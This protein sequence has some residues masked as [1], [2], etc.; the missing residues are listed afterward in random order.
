MTQ[1][2]IMVGVDVAKRWLDVQ[3]LDGE[4]FRVGNDA[5]GRAELVAR[6]VA[7]G[8]AAV[9]L[10]A[11]GGYERDA[12]ADFA[13]AGIAVRRLDPKRVR[14][15]AEAAGLLAKND[16]IDAQ[17]I[18]R[19]AALLPGRAV[20]PDARAERLAELVDARRA[21]CAERTRLVQQAERLRD[22][23]L[24]RMAARRKARI[25]ADALTIEHRL[26][27]M[28]AADPELARKDALLRSVPGVGPVLA[29]TLIA[30][31]PELGSLGGKAAAALVGVAPYDQDSGA[32]HGR[33]TTRG[34][35]TAVRNTLYMAALAGARHNPAL[36]AMRQRLAGNN[37]PP[38]LI[39]V[40]LMRKLITIL[41]AVLR[42]QQPWRTA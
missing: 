41:N 3:V 20:A 40:A 33:R 28:V 7:L 39:L 15:F 36:A 16:R 25:E 18:A 9:A 23:V 21:L 31:M 32:R 19:F 1:A 17:V 26:R 30:R 42:D 5:S 13:A 10:E 27:A 38:K 11:T 22:P 24:K 34:G 4:A 12:I 6:M 35:R 29:W 2:R 8:S 14:R 37:K